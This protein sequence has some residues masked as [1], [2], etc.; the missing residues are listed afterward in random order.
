MVRLMVCAMVCGMFGAMPTVAQVNDDFADGDF[1]SNPT[2]TGAADR[3]TVTPL[4]DNPALRNDGL[5]ASDTVY[6]ATPSTVSRGSW[7]FTFAHRDANLSNFS[8]ARVFLVANTADLTGAVQGYFVQLG[9]NNSD[10]IRLYR[11]DGDP[12]SSSNRV[13]LGASAEPLLNGDNNTLAIT[14]TRSETSEWTVSVDGQPVLTATD[15]TYFRSSF[16]GVW[17]KHTATANQNIYFDDF[18]VEGDEG[19][20]DTVPPAVSDVDY[21]EDL[22]AF[23]VAF[24]E[25]IDGTSA[26]SAAF[27]VT[28]EQQV[29][30]DFT[31][32]P[33]SGGTDPF[34]SADLILNDLLSTGNYTVAVRDLI[35]LAGNALIDTSVVVSVFRDEAPPQLVNVVAIDAQTV[36]VMFDEITNACSI[37]FYEIDNGIGMPENIAGCVPEGQSVYDLLLAQPLSSR[38]TY[39]LTVRNIADEAG[40]VLAEASAMFTFID[41]NEFDEP[42]PGDIVINEIMYD[43]P[44][45]DQ[46]YVELLNLSDKTFDLGQLQLADNRLQPVPIPPSPLLPGGY[47]VLVR[48][49]SAFGAAFP[50]VPLL[51]VG[52]WPA[53]NNSGDTSVL[54]LGEIVI[55]S[56]AFQPAW[57]GEDVSL[58]RIDPE[59]PSSS[60][61]NFGSSVAPAGGTPGAQNSI[62]A[63]D[64][65]A[66]A[67]LS[68]EQVD[69]TSLDVSFTEPLDPATVSSASFSLDDG[70][71]PD[72]VTLLEED[73]RA[74]LTF[75]IPPA[76]LHLTVRNVRDLRGNLLGEAEVPIAFQPMQSDLVI[77]EIL[78][79]PLADEEDNIPDQREY[80]E[81]FNRAN[82]FVSLRGGYWTDVPD[83]NGE[84]DTLRFGDGPFVVA[85]GAFALVFAD[86]NEAA[87]PAT[88]SDLAR[89]FPAIDFT[90]DDITLIPLDRS[91]LSLLNGGDLIHL[92]R[93]DGATLDSVFY[94]PDWHSPNLIDTKGVSLERIVGNG[95]A[96]DPL[97]WTSS[98]AEAGGTPGRPNSVF[99]PPD[100]PTTDAGL[101]IEPSPFS[102]DRDGFDDH[103]AIRYALS[104]NV[105]LIRVRIF[106]AHGR[107]VRSLQEAVLSGK[108]GQVIWD[109]LDDDGRDLRI[110]IYV[111]L[112][113]A[114]DTAGGTTEAFKQP[115]VLARP[116]D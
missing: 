7:S 81:V 105:G 1:T 49:A 108:Q 39:T 14:V 97:N 68:A 52:S 92:H 40:N 48:D 15:D 4:D 103:T 6:L 98:V 35:D 84:A 90:T 83:E 44:E 63:P 111:V 89:A 101:T 77:N 65:T 76:G 8:G 46:E 74:R 31:F 100:A 67:P 69:A 53:L 56:V 55:D 13:L 18:V 113:E 61:F 25:P 47:A 78:F 102:P 11:Q 70:R 33:G 80:F 42:V 71:S 112:L 62:F 96:N 73:T 79:D 27:S 95:A 19:P 115:V 91:S 110:G 116:L 86:P 82:R 59:G 2:W 16:F 51:E 3:W 64:V 57:G 88:D 34:T 5:A 24:S 45:T 36:R 85:P 87:D 107:L 109:G 60:R 32:V 20:A 94:D 99:I 10:E 23:R 54:L 114:I 26:S 21:L 41:P 104:S 22:P 72:A 30:V 17:V 75:G 58:E 93:A 12:S 29:D 9:T 37:T 66:P 43:P 38:T 106:D 50:G 28:D